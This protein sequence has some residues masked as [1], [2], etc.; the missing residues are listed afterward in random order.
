MWLHF[1]HKFFLSVVCFFDYVKLQ[2]TMKQNKIKPF[3]SRGK[4]PIW[5]VP[6]PVPVILI[7]LAVG[8]AIEK[9]VGDS[10]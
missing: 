2:L 7:L 6:V 5:P 4:Y 1:F 8:N 9:S 10:S 3:P